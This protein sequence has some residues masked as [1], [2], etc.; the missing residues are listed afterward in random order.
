MPDES[1][2]EKKPSEIESELWEEL[3]ALEKIVRRS[4]SE[5][6][7]QLMVAKDVAN[8][9]LLQRRLDILG[10]AENSVLE[11]RRVLTAKQQDDEHRNLHVDEMSETEKYLRRTYAFLSGK[12]AEIVPL[13]LKKK[14]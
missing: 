11:A 3:E 10:E 6:S 12:T 9:E 14:F 5:I 13:R 1:R 2:K 7:T 8:Q 4:V